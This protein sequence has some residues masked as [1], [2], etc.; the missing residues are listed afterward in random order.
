MSGNCLQKCW[1]TVSKCVGE[2]S[3]KS[4]LSGN[5]LIPC[6]SPWYCLPS[7]R[8]AGLSVQEKFNIDFQDACYSHLGF[9]IRTISAIFDLQIAQYFLSSW[10]FSSGEG[11]NGGHLGF[12]I[13]TILFIFYVQAALILLTMF[14][15]NWPFRSGQEA[16]NRFSRWRPSW[17]SD[18]NDFSYFQSTSHPDIS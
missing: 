12:Q 15:V 1:G 13:K 4:V 18:Q 14:R 6:K 7:F 8:P 2:L 17:I 9:P 5:C 3:P 10:H 11:R 16:Q